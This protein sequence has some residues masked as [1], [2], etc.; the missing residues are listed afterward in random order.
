[1]GD[2]PN[3]YLFLIQMANAHRTIVTVI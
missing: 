2:S 3:F 1:M